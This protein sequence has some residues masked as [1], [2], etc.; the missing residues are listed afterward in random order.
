MM[1]E[2]YRAFGCRLNLDDIDGKHSFV[3]YF[4]DVLSNDTNERNMA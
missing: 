3:L 2:K 4:F 1:L